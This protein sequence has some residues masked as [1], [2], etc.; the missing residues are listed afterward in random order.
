MSFVKG[1]KTPSAYFNGAFTYWIA[2]H[3]GTPFA[4]LM[5]S[6]FKGWA[7]RD[8]LGTLKTVTLDF[9]IGEEG[10]L[11]KGYGAPTLKAF[12]DFYQSLVD[13]DVQAFFIDPDINNAKAMNVYK[14]AG[15]SKKGTYVIKEG[16]FKGNTNA[17][18]IKRV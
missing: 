10:Y 2:V 5:T 15:F 4:L 7:G 8:L 9:G 17:M 18:M 13:T 11:G 16:F 14:K 6:D 12:M 1:R 3:E